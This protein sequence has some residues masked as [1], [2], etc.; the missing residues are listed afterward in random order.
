MAQSQTKLN[1]AHS[2]WDGEDGWKVN[3]R[4]AFRSFCG[5]RGWRGNIRI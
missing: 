5:Q 3:K 1:T 4:D 2:A